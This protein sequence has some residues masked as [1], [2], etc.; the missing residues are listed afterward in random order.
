MNV[1][2]TWGWALLIPLFAAC[3]AED[4]NTYEYCE[5]SS[6]CVVEADACWEVSLER[7]DGSMARSSLC[8]QE[9]TSDADC[10][11][12]VCLSLVGD[13]GETYLCYASC[14]VGESCEVGTRCTMLVDA[15]S[16]REYACFP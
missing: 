2:G 1:C 10:G 16:G 13:P 7:A 9:C 15:P 8:T 6:Q 5:E 3:A 11:G 14:G 12:G 4:R